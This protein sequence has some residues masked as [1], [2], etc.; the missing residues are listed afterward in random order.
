MKGI[1]VVRI[2][3]VYSHSIL[4]IGVEDS[5]NSNINLPHNLV[6]PL[7]GIFPTVSRPYPT[8]THV[9]SWSLLLYS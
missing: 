7:F 4:E 6:V 3:N 1:A 2:E 8:G 5:K 9:V